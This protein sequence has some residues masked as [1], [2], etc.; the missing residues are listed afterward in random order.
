[1][2]RTFKDQPYRVTG[3]WAHRYWISE[4][5]HGKFMRQCRRVVRAA[6]NRALRKGLEPEPRHPA[7]H[8]YFD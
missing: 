1:M 7:Q 8:W 3:V 5:G 6:A 4:R 2:S